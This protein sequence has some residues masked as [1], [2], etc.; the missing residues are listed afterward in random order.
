MLA[1]KAAP[2]VRA[3]ASRRLAVRVRADKCLIVNTKVKEWLSSGRSSRFIVVESRSRSLGPLPGALASPLP[4][5]F[6]GKLC[7]TMSNVMGLRQQ[8]GVAPKA[9]GVRST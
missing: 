8:R 4:A 9:G 5:D 7:A 1:K 6:R 2:A 3:S